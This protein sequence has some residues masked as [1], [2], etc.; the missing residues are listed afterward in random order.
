MQAAK[1]AAAV[2]DDH[3][4]ELF[5]HIVYTIM[6]ARPIVLFYHHPWRRTPSTLGL[7][8][9]SPLGHVDPGVRDLKADLEKRRNDS[10]AGSFKRRLL[11]N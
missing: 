6:Y 9:S 8:G 4:V 11:S 1:R 3:A 10:T 7:V 2:T 5:F